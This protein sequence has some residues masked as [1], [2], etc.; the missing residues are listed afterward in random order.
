MATKIFLGEPPANIKQW[1]IDHVASAGHADTWYK[2]E[3]DTA[4]RTVSITGAIECSYIEE[5][6]DY[7]ATIQIPD[8]GNVV[9]LEIG[10]NVTSIRDYAFR[11]C[12][13]LTSVTI[14]DSVESIQGSAFDDCS[15]ELTSVTFLGKTLEQV[16]NI[17][18]GNGN[19]RYPWGIEDTSIINVE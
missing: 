15:D 14:P 9:D 17:E 10:T 6:D 2:Y 13:N 3:G 11:G 5:E 12:N 19:K 8:I 7:E 16:Q 1:I 18:D 4:W